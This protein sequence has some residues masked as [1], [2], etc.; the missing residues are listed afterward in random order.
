MPA[1]MVGSVTLAHLIR[2]RLACVGVNVKNKCFPAAFRANVLGPLAK[3]IF[4]FDIP[5]I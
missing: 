2:K 3:L 1:A 4:K 5:H